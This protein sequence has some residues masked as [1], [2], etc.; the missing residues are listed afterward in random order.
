MRNCWETYSLQ[1]LSMRGEKRTVHA[2]FSRQHQKLI[3]KLS[4]WF[5]PAFEYLNEVFSTNIHQ[6]PVAQ[7]HVWSSLAD[8]HR[9]HQDIP[10]PQRLWGTSR[11]RRKNENTQLKLLQ[12]E[13]C[14][15]AAASH[16]QDLLRA[17]W[18]SEATV[19]TSGKRHAFH[20]LTIS[21]IPVP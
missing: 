2:V 17:I 11:V 12:Q 6:L 7:V 1:L 10:F 4:I 13:S 3:E 15:E 14:A 19:P 8:G 9:V 21:L 5:T 18:K 20:Y 16:W